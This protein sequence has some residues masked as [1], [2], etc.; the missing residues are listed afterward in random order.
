MKTSV[1]VFCVVMV[2][3]AQVA[4]ATADPDPDSDSDGILNGDDNCPY[5]ANADQRDRDDDGYG[6]AC[7]LS[8]KYAK[9]SILVDGEM[10]DWEWNDAALKKFW[11]T[12]DE[13]HPDGYIYIYIKNDDKNL[14]LLYDVVPDNSSEDCR[15]EDCDWAA[16]YID[17][18]M[19]CTMWGNDE[20]SDC[21][22]GMMEPG[23]TMTPNAAY[24]HRTWEYMVPLS[25]I[26]VDEGSDIKITVGGY[27]T[28]SLP[29][30]E[31][32]TYPEGICAGD[33]S[34]ENL[35]D[36][37]YSAVLTLAEFATEPNMTWGYETNT[38]MD[39]AV[40]SINDGSDGVAAISPLE[41]SSV[42][43]IDTEGDELWV[44][45][46]QHGQ[47]IAVGNVYDGADGDEI[48]AG[49]NH[50]GPSVTVYDASGEEIDTYYVDSDVTDIEL[51][52]L[53]EDGT[54]E[55]IVGCTY[56][57]YI[58]N[59][60]DDEGT[61]LDEVQR[62][63]VDD[64]QD[65]AI[66]DVNGDGTLD[67]VTI[68]IG[69]SDTI[70]VFSGNAE[71][72]YELLAEEHVYGQAIAV[73][74]IDGD[75]AIEIVAG[76]EDGVIVYEY[77]ADAEGDPP[78]EFS[79]V[80]EF[81]EESTGALVEEWSI[82]TD[83]S[84]MDV[85]IGSLGDA[86]VVAITQ[87]EERGTVYALDGDGNIVFL[88][89]YTG[90]Q[91]W[92]YDYARETDELRIEDINCDGRNDLIVGTEDYGVY[93]FK[94]DGTPI[95]EYFGEDTIFDVEILAL[96]GSR[97][98]VIVAVEEGVARLTS[99]VSCSRSSGGGSGSSFWDQQTIYC[100]DNSC[101]GEESC[102]SCSHDCGACPLESTPIADLLNATNTT[103]TNTTLLNTTNEEGGEEG[104]SN[105][106]EEDEGDNGPLVLNEGGSPGGTG[107]AIAPVETGGDNNWY[108]IGG[109]LLLLILLAGGFFLIRAFL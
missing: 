31:P 106:T 8:S 5:V 65:V 46:G 104:G 21:G 83:N 62:F 53:D 88:K 35:F 98:D 37:D 2:L 28:L 99:D 73:G 90:Y 79:G 70:Y 41:L 102:L 25:E 56:D 51:A 84:I 60:F 55:I 27:G 16:L 68:G 49:T 97:N 36:S 86:R 92:N 17:G 109:I 91:P 63:R 89:P 93:A 14:Y 52:D 72:E 61:Y 94:Q 74:N 34:C 78:L 85:E 29:T 3:L 26:G 59:V 12:S 67:I 4:F 101:N 43:A 96:S 64:V 33:D 24:E 13:D 7:D 76:T 6:D 57:L 87:E 42:Y 75:R 50:Q 10:S 22:S 58:L 45:H 32:W 39:T 40:G 95:W 38:P 18:A 15:G 30:G 9:T 105:S 81:R 100:G 69:S 11:F 54:D 48:V 66:G 47:R 71:D 44:D 20:L 1:A 103:L 80:L 108:M 82:E 23:F 107:L 77:D 19:S